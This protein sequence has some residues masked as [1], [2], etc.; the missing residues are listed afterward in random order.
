MSVGRVETRRN[1]AT[2]IYLMNKEKMRRPMPPVR[3]LRL[4]RNAAATLAKAEHPSIDKAPRERLSSAR[5]VRPSEMRAFMV[6]CGKDCFS[7]ERR[8]QSISQNA[9]TLKNG[10][11]FVRLRDSTKYLLTRR[12]TST[13]GRLSDKSRRERKIPGLVSTAPESRADASQLNL[14]GRTRAR[15][16]LFSFNRSS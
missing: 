9:Q 2:V 12:L 13:N 1:R 10:I 14:A 16:I 15:L 11:W 5:S 7:A 4:S 8:G 6:L 3:K